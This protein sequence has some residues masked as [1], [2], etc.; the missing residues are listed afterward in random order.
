MKTMKRLRL[1]SR[2]LIF[3]AYISFTWLALLP[4][5]HVAMHQAMNSITKKWT[6]QVRNTLLGAVLKG[7]EM[8]LAEN[9]MS[10]IIDDSRQA[11]PLD[12]I[13]IRPAHQSELLSVS[14]L[15]VN[16]FYP[17]LITNGAFHVKVLEK[18][19]TR[20]ENGSILLVA[21]ENEL[22]SALQPAG[23]RQPFLLGT[24]EF[25]PSVFLN[26]PME[27]VG[28]AKKLYV[29]DLA[30]RKSARRLGLASR[31]LDFIEDYARD[32]E[33]KELYIHVEK[34]NIPALSL[35]RKRGFMTIESAS[36]T[37]DFTKSQLPNPPEVY[38]LLWKQIF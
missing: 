27:S 6:G 4:V 5:T 17:D 11:P 21:V 13:Q 20:R 19:R 16:V 22:S 8:L 28:S 24:V 23:F 32:E 29:M 26:T 14:S 38:D 30:I 31:L 33:Y 18:L 9:I 7:S 15:W 2:N 10:T 1:T 34:S 12:S 25:S 36:H 3:A 37:D 35:Y